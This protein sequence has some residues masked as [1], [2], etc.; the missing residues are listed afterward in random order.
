M[1]NLQKKGPSKGEQKIIDILNEE[2]IKYEREKNFTDEKKVAYYRFDFYL[3]DYNICLEFQGMQHMVYSPFFHKKRSDFTK[4]Q[5]RDR[6]KI[7]YCLAHNIKLYCI[8]YW[9]LEKLYTFEDLIKPEYLARSKF[10]NDE[11]YRQQK[12]KEKH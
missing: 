10:H 3:P 5:E 2:K 4:A 7:S 8:P 1:K 6:T 9:D 12:L 11:A